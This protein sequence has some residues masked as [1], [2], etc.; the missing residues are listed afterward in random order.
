MRKLVKIETPGHAF[1]V[2]KSNNDWF[3][4][5]IQT[6]TTEKLMRFQLVG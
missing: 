3:D 2:E 4:S 1:V 6:K 5:F